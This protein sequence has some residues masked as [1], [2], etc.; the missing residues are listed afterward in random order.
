LLAPI[1]EAFQEEAADIV[2]EEALELG[3]PSDSN[4]AA[5]EGGARPRMRVRHRFARDASEVD[6]AGELGAARIAVLRD[7]RRG[8]P[9]STDP[10][11]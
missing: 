1:R 7:R 8:R 5:N 11:A 4:T 10:P 3:G 2:E 9:K 6:Q